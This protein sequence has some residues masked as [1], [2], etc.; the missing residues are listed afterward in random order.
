MLSLYMCTYWL[1]LSLLKLAHRETGGGGSHPSTVGYLRLA[2]YC[3]SS[4]SEAVLPSRA[5]D[6]IGG[7]KVQNFGRVMAVFSAEKRGLA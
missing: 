1:A 4:V 2:K 5:G 6:V 7:G 3:P